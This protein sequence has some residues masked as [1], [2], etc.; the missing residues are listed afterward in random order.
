MKLKK[1]SRIILLLVAF[2]TSISYSQWWTDLY[3]FKSATV[4]LTSIKPDGKGN[5]FL[6]GYHFDSLVIFDTLLLSNGYEDCFVLKIDTTGK[7]LSALNFGGTGVDRIFDIAVKKDGN[8]VV[9]GVFQKEMQID[10]TLLTALVSESFFIAEFTKDNS[11]LWV[12]VSS[13]GEGLSLCTN[14][15]GDVVVSGVLR[16]EASFT[17]GDT[18]HSLGDED[19]FL[20]CYDKEGNI[21][22][23]K[24]MGG[25]IF[26]RPSHLSYWGND[27]FY[28]SGTFVDTFIVDSDTIVSNS[29]FEQGFIALFDTGGSLLKLFPILDLGEVKVY[30]FV[31]DSNG[32]IFIAGFF[33][34]SVKIDTLTVEAE[35]ENSMLIAALTSEGRVKWV[36]KA[37]SASANDITFGPNN[38]LYV[39]GSFKRSTKFGEYEITSTSVEDIF[40]A[41]YS[42]EGEFKWLLRAGGCRESKA[43]KIAFSSPLFFVSGITEINLET[44]ICH[45][46]FNSR[47]STTYMLNDRGRAFLAAGN[48]LLDSLTEVQQ[49]FK[50]VKSMLISSNKIV[51]A[52]DIRGRNV[53]NILNKNRIGKVIPASV[54]I[55]ET[56]DKRYYPYLLVK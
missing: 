1:I 32:N 45:I 51:R 46:E 21:R 56:A 39:C 44:A 20:V 55:T 43:K 54:I 31:N 15:N 40:V 38:D 2:L 18:I 49:P 24:R 48:Y 37:Q 23:A 28:L 25:N 10:D 19:I 29:L 5:I 3:P 53:S 4:S 52:Y 17:E 50:M 33:S 9:T 36:A 22:W 13:A 8:F 7:L 41:N 34:S 47:I 11:L 42:L 12:R 6:A 16:G 26:E 27:K 14:D 35:G 30:S